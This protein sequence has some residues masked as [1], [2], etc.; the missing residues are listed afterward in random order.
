VQCRRLVHVQ[1]TSHGDFK[2]TVF[3][4]WND[5]M[6]DGL[7]LPVKVVAGKQHGRLSGHS[8]AHQS[9]HAHLSGYERR[10]RLTGHEAGLPLVA[11]NIAIAMAASD[12]STT[13]T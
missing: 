11:T 9:L 1:T 2:I 5:I 7:V 12:S 10:W 4:Q 13:P 6:L 3:D 8:V